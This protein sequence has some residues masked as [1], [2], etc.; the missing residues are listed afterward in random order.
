MIKSLE[1]IIINGQ[2]CKRDAEVARA[3]N[4]MSEIPKK[5]IVKQLLSYV[6]IFI[7]IY[8]APFA[9]LKKY[10]SDYVEQKI[11]SVVK[12]S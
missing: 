10:A 8:N 2:N 3:N 5:H 6:L 12:S 4:H 9:K 7:G 11:Q 1:K